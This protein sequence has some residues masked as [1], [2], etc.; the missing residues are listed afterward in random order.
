MS[1]TPLPSHDELARA[2]LEVSIDGPIATVC[3]DRPQKFNA[4]TPTMWAGLT[5][6]GESLPGLGVHVVV[7]TGNGRC[8]SAGLDRAMLTPEGPEGEQSLVALLEGSD[9]EVADRIAVF[10]SGFTWLQRDDLVSIAA[11]HGYAIGG[12]FQL[13]L[14]C[15]IR[16]V[17]DDVQFCMKEPALGLVPDLGGTKPLVAAVGY[18]RALEICA[19]A[20]FVG[21]HDAVTIGLA[22]LAV[23]GQDLLETASDLAQAIAANRPAAVLGTKSLLR[24]APLRTL[25]DQCRAEREAQIE[26]L[27]ALVG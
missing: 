21:A 17:A 4:M 2:G 13:A 6:V 11:V 8:F 7:L 25:E 14:A 24:S 23:P 9:Q 1:A 10:Q 26:R 27:R 19:T 12:G 18:S 16:V 5:A 20:R 22:A 15:D 3:L